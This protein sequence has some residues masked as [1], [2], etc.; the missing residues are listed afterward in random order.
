MNTIMIYD[1]ISFDNIMY[2]RDTV[3]LHRQEFKLFEKHRN[4]SLRIVI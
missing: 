1:S 3:I 2:I 4:P